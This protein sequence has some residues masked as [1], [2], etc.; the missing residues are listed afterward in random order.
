[1]ASAICTRLAFSNSSRE[2]IEQLVNRHMAFINLPNMRESTLK[3][4]LSSSF[5]SDELEL[6][7]VDSL[8]SHGSLKTLEF[9]LNKLRE[10]ETEE[11]SR[12]SLPSPLVNGRDLIAMGLRPGPMFSTILAEVYDAQLEN[13]FI[14][15]DGALDFLKVAVD[16][17]K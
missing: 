2:V 12:V 5:L 9:T 15:R 11:S 10:F 3:R 4:F 8:A 6:H 16:R 14:D 17:N 1:M 13:Q 7:R